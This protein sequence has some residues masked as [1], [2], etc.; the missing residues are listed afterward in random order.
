MLEELHSRNGVI[1]ITANKGS[2]VVILDASDYLKKAKRKP[3]D[4]KN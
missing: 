4:T 3:R 1:I 2:A